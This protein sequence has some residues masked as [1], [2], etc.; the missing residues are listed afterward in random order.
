MPLTRVSQ[1]LTKD[2]VKVP[3]LY[4]YS[5][6]ITFSPCGATGRMGPTLANARSTYTSQPNQASWLNDLTLFFVDNGIQYWRVPKDGTYTIR[7]AGAG[8]RPSGQTYSGDGAIIQAQFSLIAG[9]WLRIVVGQQGISS[10]TTQTMGGSGGSAVSVGRGNSQLLL[11]C[12][13]GGGGNSSNSSG[14]S[15]TDRNASYSN[16]G[17]PE[18]GFGSV[19]QTGYAAASNI[20]HYWPGG[21]GGGWGRDG[22]TGGIGGEVSKHQISGAMLSGSALGGYSMNGNHGGFGGGGSTGRDGGA[23]GGGGGYKG[24]HAESWAGNQAADYPKGGESYT[25][26]GATQTNIGMNSSQG[27]VTVTL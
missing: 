15:S 27:Y 3:T 12:A 8:G 7:A 5:G 17:I 4:N 2:V 25:G 18:G 26:L 6:T 21:G 10:Y 9:E 11:L 20:L 24:G 22:M 19:W 14:G 23:A 16:S 13:G 1:N